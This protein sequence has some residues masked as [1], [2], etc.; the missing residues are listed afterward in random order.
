MELL[1]LEKFK[2]LSEEQRKN[3]ISI[4]IPTYRTGENE[5]SRIRFKNRIQ[6]VEKELEERHVKGTEIA[7]TLRPLNDMLEDSRLWRHLSDGLAVFLNDETFIT[8]SLPI[9]FQ[10]FSRVSDRFHLMY[11]IPYFNGDGRF[12]ILALSLQEVRLYEGTRH[13]IG[14]VIIDDLVPG[15]LEDTVGYDFEQKNLQY[16]TGQSQTGHKMFHGHGAGKDD[17]NSE[18]KKYLRHVDKGL[19]GILQGDRSPMVVASVDELF[20]TYRQISKYNHIHDENI[21]GNPD[22]EDMFILHEKAWD[23]LE[24]HFAGQ[25]QKSLEAYEFSKS[26]DQAT[27]DPD[28]AVPAASEGR[29]ETIFINQ[30]RNLWGKFDPIS[31]KITTDNAPNPENICLLDHA[32]RTVILQGGNVYLCNGNEMP[33]KDASIAAILR[34]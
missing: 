14:E 1:T 8:F 32:A 10:E 26:R 5:R 19:W 22:E 29:V 23:L 9:H 20:A 21:K 25:R 24:D 31:H 28:K 12:L 4:Y 6:S 34:Y 3:S 17:K 27:S 16:R 33:V 7:N 13:E 30:N 2:V 18:V 15:R 11:L